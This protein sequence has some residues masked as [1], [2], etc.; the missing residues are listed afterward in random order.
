MPR[1]MSR[2]P[3]SPS[4]APITSV[5]GAR[6][7]ARPGAPSALVVRQSWP[8]HEKIGDFLA[9]LRLAVEAKANGQTGSIGGSPLTA[10]AETAIAETLASRG[11]VAV[12]EAKAAI[13]I[14]LDLSLKEGQVMELAA[15]ERVFSSED[16]LEGA[17]AFIEKR[18]AEFRNR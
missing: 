11:P 7:A 15:S 3:C 9:S 2:A 1:A 16:M 12:R 6:L 5:A 4:A 17:A 18:P 10:R 8:V 14:A 13:D